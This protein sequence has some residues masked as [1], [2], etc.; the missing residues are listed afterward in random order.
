MIPRFIDW[1]GYFPNP[2]LTIALLH[3]F[4]LS[5]GRIKRMF[6]W[7][8]WP[9]TMWVLMEACWTVFWNWRL[10]AAYYNLLGPTMLSTQWP[11][12]LHP[13]YSY[14]IP[15]DKC[16]QIIIINWIRDH[17]SCAQW[18]KWVVRR[19][20]SICF[21]KLLSSWKWYIKL[22]YMI[23]TC[24]V[25]NIQLVYDIYNNVVPNMIWK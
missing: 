22:F 5:R 25:H 16:S 13:P 17:C 10:K 21:R 14:R 9:M 1:P 8:L 19:C 12:S 23:W 24:N 7:S 20:N 2:D 6:V 18:P 15:N 3:W 4:L 11:S